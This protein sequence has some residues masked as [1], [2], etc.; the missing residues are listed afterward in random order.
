MR[1]I[2]VMCVLLASVLLYGCNQTG[3]VPAGEK[4]AT[5]QAMA[6]SV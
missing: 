2:G 6:N 4:P 5:E 1:A 3:S